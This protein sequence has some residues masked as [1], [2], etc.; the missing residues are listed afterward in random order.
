[1]LTIALSRQQ[2]SGLMAGVDRSVLDD[3][4]H[5][6]TSRQRH[7]LELRF[8]LTDGHERTLEEV[9]QE[10]GVTRER[11]RQIEKKALQRLMHP[12]RR[13]KLRALR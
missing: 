10:F 12:S 5:T 3:I 6:L 13:R 4:L 1:M 9:G 11:I 7:V 8:G 2:D